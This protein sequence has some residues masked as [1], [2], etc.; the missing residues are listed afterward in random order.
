MSHKNKNSWLLPI[1]IGIVLLLFILLSGIFISCKSTYTPWQPDK[2]LS[3][4]RYKHK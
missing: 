4:K 3:H 1:A 2:N